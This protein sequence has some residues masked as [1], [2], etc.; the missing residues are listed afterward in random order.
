MR[1]ARSFWTYL[2]AIPGTPF[3]RMAFCRPP[4][5]RL[6]YPDFNPKCPNQ[7]RNSGLSSG[8]EA[9]VDL[10]RCIL[11]AIRGKACRDGFA[12][13]LAELPRFGGIRKQ[14]LDRGCQSNGIEF[15]H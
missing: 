6:A 12:R 3:S 1:C 15:I 2:A 11:H 4:I 14:A 8:D 7:I 9:F 13:R 5:W 10:E